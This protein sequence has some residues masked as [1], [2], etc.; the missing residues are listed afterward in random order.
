MQSI[1]KMMMFNGHFADSVAKNNTPFRYKDRFLEGKQY[2]KR[3]MV[4]PIVKNALPRHC[5]GCLEKVWVMKIDRE[6]L[7]SIDFINNVDMHLSEE[8]W[9][10]LESLELNVGGHQFDRVYFGEGNTGFLEDLYK[11][12]VRHCPGGKVIVPLHMCTLTDNCLM[13]IREGLYH[14]VQF[15]ARFAKERV[16][17]EIEIWADAYTIPDYKPEDNHRMITQQLQ[18]TGYDLLKNGENVIPLNYNHPMHAIY[19]HG[20]AAMP[21]IKQVRLVLNDLGWYNGPLYPIKEDGKDY[22]KIVM[23]N[24]DV[25]K[26]NQTMIPNFSRIDKARLV[27][28]VEGMPTEN[29][30][31]YVFGHSYQI[32]LQMA[33]MYGLVF[34]K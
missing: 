32:L 4:M 3:H 33:G 15:I 30:K 8:G 14:D 34:S 26:E 16:Y 5:S 27:L 24:E 25:I 7:D 10:D 1:I 13:P 21:Y 2:F 29:A 20:A 12:H 17:P 9:K 31:M 23:V 6:N 28:T 19:F 22:A 11:R 18:H